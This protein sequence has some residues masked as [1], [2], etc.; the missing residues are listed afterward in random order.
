MIPHRLQAEAFAQASGSAAGCPWSLKTDG[1]R[2]V[3]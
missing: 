2:R 1:R 3:S